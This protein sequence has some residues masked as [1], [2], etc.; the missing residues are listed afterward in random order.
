MSSENIRVA[1][2][3]RL[4]AKLC[5]PHQCNCGTLVDARGLHGLSCRRSAGRHARHSLLN[6]IIWR[7]LNKAGVQSTKE[8]TGLLQSDGKRPDGVMLIPWAKGRCLTWDVTVPDTFAT[9]HIASTSYLPGAAAEYTATLKKQKYVTNTWIRS[10]S[11]W[12]KRCIQ[13]EGEDFVKQIGSR[14]S[15]ASSDEKRSLT[16]SSVY[17]SRSREGT[18]SHFLDLLSNVTISGSLLQWKAS[19]SN[20]L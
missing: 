14:I 4:G 6:D 1:V 9:S 12:N 5:E 18:V 11:N 3:L 7:A 19:K 10:S 2:G 16:C 8:S 13:S 15:N 20:K 17:P